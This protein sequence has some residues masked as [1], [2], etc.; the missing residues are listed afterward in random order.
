[1]TAPRDDAEDL[2]AAPMDATALAITAANA[3]ADRAECE[4]AADL[5]ATRAAVLGAAHMLAAV[6]WLLTPFP[7]LALNALVPAVS[8]FR[9]AFPRGAKVPSDQGRIDSLTAWGQTRGG[10]S[11]AWQA[12][13]EAVGAVSWSRAR[14]A[15]QTRAYKYALLCALVTMSVSAIA[16]VADL[17]LW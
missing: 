5:M 7:V 13:T 3:R 4:R 8:G 16:V 17:L 2:S 1:M 11:L 9:A 10:E 14:L 15:E 12:A 6:V